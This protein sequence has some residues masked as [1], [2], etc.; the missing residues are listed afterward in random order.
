MKKLFLTFAASLIAFISFAQTGGIKATVVN[1]AGRA[2]VNNARISL[3]KGAELIAD[4]TSSQ[5]GTFFFQN[6]EDG[7]YFLK[8]SADGFV[9]AHINVTVEKGLVRD[10]VFVTLTAEQTVA[11]FDD[12]NFAEFD[13]DDSGFSDTPA[14][15]LGSKDPYTSI[16]GYGFSDV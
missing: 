6:L 2:P 12:S 3:Q 9:D 10:L 16:A 1:R 11:E 5:D 13:M 14:I 8:V 7:N 4:F 15:M